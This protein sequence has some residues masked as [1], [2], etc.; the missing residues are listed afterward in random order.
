[1]GC[2]ISLTT[3]RIPHRRE[4]C[5][6]SSDETSESESLLARQ[7]CLQILVEKPVKQ[8]LSGF[9]QSAY[10]CAL[11]YAAFALF[12]ALVDRR[13]FGSLPAW[14]PVLSGVGVATALGAAA[15]AVVLLP[16]F[17]LGKVSD[18]A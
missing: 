15:G 12:R 4:G 17:E 3:L 13:R 11:V 16:L 18:R 6:R 1:M 9:P 8:V 7:P 10:I 5:G 2:L 14:L